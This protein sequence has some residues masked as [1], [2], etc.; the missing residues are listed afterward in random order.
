MLVAVLGSALTGCATGAASGRGDGPPSVVTSF[1]P[2]QYVTA[3]IAGSTARVSSLTAP[4]GEPH[5]LELTPRQVARVSDAD[6]VVYLGGF[7]PSVDDAVR[8]DARH[9]L[10]VAA[11][12]SLDRAD[13]DD[14]RGAL[15]PHFWLDPARL[16]AV[17]ALIERRLATLEP[18]DA[19]QFRA[20]LTGLTDDLTA[21]GRAY[22][23]G[24]AHCA[25]PDLVT[26]HQAFGYLAAR[27]GFDQV[28]IAGLSPDEEPEAASMAQVARF[29]RSHHV[30][31]VYTET[32]VSPAIARTVAAETGA[33]TAVLD[34]IE[35]ITPNSAGRDY[36]AVMRS[37]L[38][39]LREGQ[40]CT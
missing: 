1:Y 6:L 25:N 37:N 17:S 38:A 32:L 30:R 39:T 13:P 8:Q 18:A 2:L 35:S 5:D 27:Y 15:D 20:N 12:A 36:L 33:R 28:G 26:G 21:L 9:H 22:A 34:P 11:A 14:P 19:G 24:L 4:G 23:T 10:D 40:P 31:T 7:Q 29:V 16:A 3:R